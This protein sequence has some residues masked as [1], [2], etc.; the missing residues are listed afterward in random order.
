MKPSGG[1]GMRCPKFFE[2]FFGFNTFV[3]THAFF[4]NNPR[5]V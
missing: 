3:I 4:C 5:L 2:D 1:P